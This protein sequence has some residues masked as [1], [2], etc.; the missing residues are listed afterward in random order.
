M[1][2][3]RSI[4]ELFYL[5]LRGA[6]LASQLELY[7]RSFDLFMMLF[8]VV[9]ISGAAFYELELSSY[10]DGTVSYL[11]QAIYWACVTGETMLT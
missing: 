8:A 1:R 9:F 5:W 10:E 4:S 7:K 11:H 2:F 6:A 3:I